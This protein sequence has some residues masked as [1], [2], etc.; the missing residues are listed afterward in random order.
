MPDSK[1]N[2][3]KERINAGEAYREERARPL[4]DRIGERAIE[5]K[6]SFTSFAKEHPVTTIVGGVAIGAL[7]AMMFRTP[8]HAASKA[9]TQASALAALGAK[10]AMDYAQQAMHAAGD[11]G[12]A[13]VHGLESL[14]DS[15]ESATRGLRR[16]ASRSAHDTGSAARHA[17]HEARSAIRKALHRSH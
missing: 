5:A 14:G 13:G 12:R 17:A 16:S 2:Q 11:A 15:A 7:V 9:G 6:D 10:L 4:S 8:R 3:L 1:R